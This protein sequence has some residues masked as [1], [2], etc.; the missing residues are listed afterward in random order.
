MTIAFDPRSPEFR[1]NPYP[2]YDLL[3][4]HAPIFYWEVWGITF[5]TRHEDCSELLRDNRLGRGRPVE[6][7]SQ[8]IPLYKMQMDW[9]LL[10]NPPDHTR[11][12]GLVHKA[13]SPRMVEQLR[14]MI[15]HTTD[16]LLDQVQAQH[17]M[18]LITDFAYPLPV[19][20]IAEMLGVPEADR[21]RF[22]HWS[23]ALARSLDLTD[24]PAVY[25]RASVAAAEFT[26]Y[27]RELVA[28]RRV[29]PTNDLLSAL[30]AV[31]EA[32]EQLTENE[33]YATCALLLIAGHETTI[34]LIGNGSL[35]LLRNPSQ[36]RLLQNDASLIRGAIEEL[37]RYDGPVQMTSRTVLEEVKFQGHRFQPGQEVAFMLGAAN[38][39][40]TVFHDPHTLDVTRKKNPHLTFG[41]GIHYCLGA[42]LARL[43]GQIAFETLTRR[44]PNLRFAT[45]TP[46]Y[47]DNYVL[48]G[49]EALPVEF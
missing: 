13:F 41:G 39:D 16:Q 30:V 10:Q 32:G 33:L 17:G 1:R 6:P 48:R 38:Y 24:D 5:L 44:L 40:P 37:L 28:Q 7:L 8:Q 9:M 25:D 42:P 18:D 35:A 23:D 34:N 12:R 4:T 11:L 45:D 31:E 46:V 36:W 20:V 22:H 19:T 21:L 26:D 43:E 49:L 3:R 29:A 15:Q 47:R 2:Y 27:L 14:D